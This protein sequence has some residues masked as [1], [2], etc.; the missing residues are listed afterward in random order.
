VSIED[1]N[2]KKGEHKMTDMMT[3]VKTI[4]LPP[5][6]ERELG[7]EKDW[8]VKVEPAFVERVCRT[9]EKHRWVL[10]ELSRK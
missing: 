3:K 6:V 4:Q 10:K 2:S 1:A 9:A 5:R 8:Q 7:L